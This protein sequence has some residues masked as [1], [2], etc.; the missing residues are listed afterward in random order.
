[1]SGPGSGLRLALLLHPAKYRRERGEELAAV[2]ADIADG[3][4][5]LATARELI[6]LA[7]HGVRLRLGLGSDGVPGQLAAL[8]APFAVT[9]AAAGGLAQQIG[10][11]T[12]LP[13][14]LALAVLRFEYSGWHPVLLG[15]FGVLVS[16]V[17]AVAAVCGRWTT[18]RLTALLGLVLTLVFTWISLTGSSS[19]E[20]GQVQLVA[21]RA[22]V[23]AGPQVLWVLI[24]LAAPRD[25]LGPAT[26]RRGWTALAGAVLGGLLLNTALGLGP[27]PVL[28]TD[29]SVPLALALAAAELALLAAAVPALLRG[30]QGPAAAAVAGSPVAALMLFTVLS[31]VWN[32]GSHVTAVVLFGA[33]VLFAVALAHWLP[34]LPDRRPP[35]AD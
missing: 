23:R 9:A 32:T 25:L 33:A 27:V 1:M 12:N 34:G 4:G 7:G 13:P 10:N 11:W 2:F 22:I 6:D 31:K 8:A 15:Q 14:G 28:N 35:R 18:A 26:R 24:L 17:A 21:A 30:R 20:V 3:S 5:R 16:L 29:A 19:W